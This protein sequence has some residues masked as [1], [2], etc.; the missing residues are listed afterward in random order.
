MVDSVAGVMLLAAAK[1]ALSIAAGVV[2]VKVT[3]AVALGAAVDDMEKPE[4]CPVLSMLWRR[5]FPYAF[6]ARAL[7]EPTKAE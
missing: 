7:T 4:A 6:S 1:T 2:A 3:A 5:A